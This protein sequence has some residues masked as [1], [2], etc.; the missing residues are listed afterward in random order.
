[1]VSAMMETRKQFGNN[2]TLVSVR[3]LFDPAK[4]ARK[5]GETPLYRRVFLVSVLRGEA[6]ACFGHTISH[7]ISMNN[8]VKE[9]TLEEAA[10]PPNWSLRQAAFDQR[11]EKMRKRAAASRN[12]VAAVE[13]WFENEVPARVAESDEGIKLAST[14]A[15]AMAALEAVEN[16]TQGPYTPEWIDH[17]RTLTVDRDGSAYSLGLVSPVRLSGGFAWEADRRR[18]CQRSSRR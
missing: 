17:A 18:S 11:V 14:F 1:M 6:G 13:K 12:L 16:L 9:S 3:R 15:P 7:G 4:D 10:S 2:F 5:Q 8:T